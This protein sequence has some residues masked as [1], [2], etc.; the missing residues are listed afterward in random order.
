MRPPLNALPLRGL[1]IAAILLLVV[2]PTAA[3][4]V[5]W[6]VVEHH[7]QT[8]LFRRLTSAKAFI[9]SGI[10]HTNSA[11]WPAEVQHRLEGVHMVA[12]ITERTKSGKHQIYPRPPVQTGPIKTGPAVFMPNAQSSVT[13]YTLARGRN[14]IIVSLGYPV[15]APSVRAAWALV[16]GL[17]TAAVSLVLV[18]WLLGRWVSRPLREL[19]EDVDRIA[20][21]E[22]LPTR[23]PSRVREVENIGHAIAGMSRAL[24]VAR[25]GEADVDRERRFLISAIA[26]DL[27]TPLFALRGYLQAHRLGVG[28]ADEDYLPLAEAKAEQ[29]DR[30]V[31]DLFGYTRLELLDERP[32]FAAVDLAELLERAADAF[33]QSA[34]AHSAELVVSPAVSVHVLGNEDMLE[35]AASNLI[36][37]AIR[38]GE[39]NGVIRVEWG[40]AGG[41]GWF[42]VSDNGPG[43]SDQEM[44][45]LFDPLYQANDSRRGGGGA[46]LGLAIAKRIVDAHGGE[47]TVR[48]DGGA[49]FTVTLPLSNRDAPSPV[50]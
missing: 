27:R 1:I 23:R 9:A 33:K 38:H 40:E 32:A 4:F 35:R 24:A 22:A 49:V 3:G 44:P 25:Q 41:E 45:R 20:S 30:L 5:A 43:I 17:S 37:N 34:A 42:S 14:P 50:L 10:S 47:I 39:R 12:V 11:N 7:Q 19:S 48:N 13:T 16:V 15:P 36:D 29:I 6:R 26:H 46:G 18:F 28:N 2:V 8:A 31:A 21:G